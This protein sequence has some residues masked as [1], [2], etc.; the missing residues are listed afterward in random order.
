MNNKRVTELENCAVRTAMC[1]VVLVS[2]DR[3]NDLTVAPFG[4]L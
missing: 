1:T 4:N 2:V 3:I